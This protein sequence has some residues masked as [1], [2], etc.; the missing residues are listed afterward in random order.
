MRTELHGGGHALP[1]LSRH[2]AIRTQQRCIPPFMVDSLIAWGEWSHAGSGASK[3]AFSKRSWR[4]FAG[5]LGYEAK[6]F[7]RYRNVY[8]VVGTDGTVITVGWRQ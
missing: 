1:T 2:A 7:E 3:Y 5:H 4:K 8:V 6:R